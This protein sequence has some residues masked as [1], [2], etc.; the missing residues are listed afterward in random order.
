MGD[1]TGGE[2]ATKLCANAMRNAALITGEIIASPGTRSH[3]A[4]P[5]RE[6]PEAPGALN[7]IAAPSVAATVARLEQCVNE[8]DELQRTLRST[9][10]RAAADGE[11][12]AG[13]AMARVDAVRRLAALAHHAW[14]S[15]LHLANGG[16]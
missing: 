7:I 15:T 11:L 8:L 10:L 1:V 13:E 9:T 14:R 5:E 2:R 6:L 4:N 16:A 12:T 3:A